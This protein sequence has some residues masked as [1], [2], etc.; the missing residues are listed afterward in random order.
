LLLL[1][2]PLIVMSLTKDR[3]Q[4]YLAPLAPRG[5]CW[6]PTRWSS[7]APAGPRTSMGQSGPRRGGHALAAARC[8]DRA[9]PRPRLDRTAAL[10]LTTE[11]HPWFTPVEVQGWAWPR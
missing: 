3:Y 4:R 8:H 2:V 1:L 6:Q 10:V 9:G 5:R 7:T 11:G